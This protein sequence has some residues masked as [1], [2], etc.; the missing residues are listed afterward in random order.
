[1][2]GSSL[3][4]SHRTNMSTTSLY[5]TLDRAATLCDSAHQ[6]LLNLSD[7]VNP[8]RISTVM[9]SVS[10][11]TRGSTVEDLRLAIKADQ[12][13]SAVVD[14]AAGVDRD[15]LYEAVFVIVTGQVDRANA[16]QSAL[17]HKELETTW[18]KP[19]ASKTRAIW[20]MTGELRK[21]VGEAKFMAGRSTGTAA[22]E[23]VGKAN[24][25]AFGINTEVVTKAVGKIRGFAKKIREQADAI[26]RI[27]E[28]PDPNVDT[29][30]LSAMQ[31]RR[32]ALEKETVYVEKG[33]AEH[34]DSGSKAICSGAKQALKDLVIPEQLAKGRGK[35]LVL[36]V[37]SF[38]H[39]RTPKFYAILP[40]AMLTMDDAVVGLFSEPPSKA[41]DYADVPEVLRELYAE[42]SKWLWEEFERKLPKD[43]QE[44]PPSTLLCQYPL[45]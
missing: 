29:S 33:L 22:N 39:M 36:N 34:F 13:L 19:A 30:G 40:Q 26:S 44:A 14:K 18:A 16:R 42:Q 31:D 38:F 35:D 2:W 3:P 11:G 41:D 21:V 5:D 8:G 17:V 23:A 20:K 28:D 10:S 43:I 12:A 4:N 24:Q 32:T 9:G 37:K 1:M 15:A 7:E 27:L 25:E 6:E 45:M